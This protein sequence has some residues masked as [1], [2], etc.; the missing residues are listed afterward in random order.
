M[1]LW[2]G[3]IMH[4]HILVRFVTVLLL[5][6]TTQ[7]APST[8]TTASIAITKGV[9]VIGVPLRVPNLGTLDDVCRLIDARF[10]VV[11][12]GDRWHVVMAESPEARAYTVR[13]NESYVVFASRTQTV[14]VSGVPWSASE[15]VRSIPRGISLVRFFR[16]PVD[17]AERVRRLMGVSAILIRSPGQ[18]SIQWQPVALEGQQL[19]EVLLNHTDSYALISPTTMAPIVLPNSNFP[20]HARIAGIPRAATQGT[21]LT[22][23]SNAVDD[24]PGD[25]ELSST[26][27]V[28]SSG[29]ELIFSVGRSVVVTMAAQ[30]MS[31]E[32]SCTDGLSSD[33][34]TQSI[35]VIPSVSATMNQEIRTGFESFNLNAFGVRSTLPALPVSFRTPL[36]AFGYRIANNPIDGTRQ[37][38]IEEAA[39]H[40]LTDAPL[41]ITL[42]VDVGESPTADILVKNAVVYDL[43]TGQ[44]TTFDYHAFTQEATSRT[45]GAA[46]KGPIAWARSWMTQL[47]NVRRTFVPVSFQNLVSSDD[48]YAIEPLNPNLQL[49]DRILVFL[50]SG[51]DFKSEFCAAGQTIPQALARWNW[52]AGIDATSPNGIADNLHDLER[53]FAFYR[54]A[55]PT[56]RTP[57]EVA[58]KL[59]SLL[60]SSVLTKSRRVII[61]GY[62]MGGIVGRY[63]QNMLNGVEALVTIGTPHHGSSIATALKGRYFDLNFFLERAMPQEAWPLLHYGCVPP[64]DGLASLV[65]DEWWKDSNGEILFPNRNSTLTAF[66]QH[67]DAHRQDASVTHVAGGTGDIPFPDPEYEQ[68]RQI[69]RQPTGLV[70]HEDSDGAVATESALPKDLHGWQKGSTDPFFGWTDSG[71][72][73]RVSYNNGLDHQL[74]LRHPT[75][76]CRY[77]TFLSQYMDH[78]NH[79]P[80][81]DTPQLV[82]LKTFESSIDLTSVEQA[83]DPDGDPLFHAWSLHRV[84]PADAHAQLDGTIVTVS[85]PGNAILYHTVRDGRGGITATIVVVYRPAPPPD[86]FCLTASLALILE[87][88]TDQTIHWI[89]S[90]TGCIPADP[91]RYTLWI[92]PTDDTT[93]IAGD[94]FM[95][96]GAHRW[97][98]DREMYGF[99]DGPGITTPQRVVTNVAVGKSQHAIL[100]NR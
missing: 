94:N 98:S 74:I 14:V 1:S 65:Y 73:D 80:H 46:A 22:F 44:T 63:L 100:L 41:P 9:S 99:Y 10:I 12:A 95:V 6:G 71:V 54:F 51:I 49:D 90:P 91:R 4:I 31:V 50:I 62:S 27:K 64:S 24:D 11:S 75:M 92:D 47:G 17:D 32:H 86:G 57:K 56:T 88:H 38:D 60:T 84:L 55:Y 45:A 89:V 43:K 23:E 85:S 5:V 69:W 2:R 21:T 76:I 58:T 19:P 18:S 20:P 79:A 81:D 67:D 13:G 33:R 35:A 48:G 78:R 68:A 61:F 53:S 40:L 37:I 96:Y 97:W 87:A 52:F 77:H 16:P 3:W 39:T 30:E 59:T 26:W 8:V 66:N 93:K 7:A 36:P 83:V 28:F 25:E 42:S 70:E 34:I 72:V 29:T 15:L 82:T